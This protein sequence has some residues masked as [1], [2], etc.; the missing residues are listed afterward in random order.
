MLLAHVGVILRSV[1]YSFPACG[2]GY[3]YGMHMHFSTVSVAGTLPEE[4]VFLPD[5]TFPGLFNHTG[6]THECSNGCMWLWLL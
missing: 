3:A 4:E 2:Y 5:L 1:W 6:A